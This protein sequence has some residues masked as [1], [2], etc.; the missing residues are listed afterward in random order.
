M[1]TSVASPNALHKK[2]E[3]GW[4]C[5]KNLMHAQLELLDKNCTF[6][7]YPVIKALFESKV[8]YNI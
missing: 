5:P 1:V 4:F 6:K 7:V 3:E 8:C 2:Q